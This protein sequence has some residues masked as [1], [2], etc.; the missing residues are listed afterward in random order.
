MHCYRTASALAHGNC[1]TLSV[2]HGQKA[3]LFELFSFF[4][5]SLSQSL[6]HSDLQQVHY[7][8]ETAV[9]SWQGLFVIASNSIN[10]FTDQLALHS[11]KNKTKKQGW[12]SSCFP[13]LTPQI[14][15]LSIS[16]CYGFPNSSSSSCIHSSPG[17]LL[18]MESTRLVFSVIFGKD[19]PVPSLL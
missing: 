12:T 13:F 10:A 3:A 17:P 8:M 5:L 16:M 15:E 11:F 2:A 19:P 6:S 1:L 4:S 18:M 9:G 7:G 14:L